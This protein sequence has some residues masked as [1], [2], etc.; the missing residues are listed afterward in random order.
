MAAVFDDEVF[1]HIGAIAG[2]DADAA[3]VDFAGLARAELVEFEN[4]SAFDQHDFADRS[5]HGASHFGMQLQLAIF[6]MDWDEVARLDQIDDQLELFLTGVSADMDW[7]GGSVFIDDVGFAAEEMVDHPVDGFFVAGDD[8]AGENDRVTLFDFGMLMI[9]DR[10][11][12]QRRHGL[13]LRAADQDTDFFRRE[14]L[15]LP[16]IDDQSLGEFDVAEIFG[17][18]RRV[19]HG[20]SD[21]GDLASVLMGEFDGEVDAV[22]RTGEARNEEAALGVREDLVELAA[23]GA[24]AGR[25]SLALDVGGILKKRQHALFAIFGEGVQIE[26]L[27]VGGRRIDFEITG[28]DDDAER[29]VNGER[30]TIDQAVRD[31][32]RMDGEGSG[33]EAL[34]SAHLA[35][36]GIVEQSVLVEL[37]LDIGEREFGAPDG[38]LQF[39]E[40]PR[41][42]AN[43]VLMA[44]SEDDAAHALAIF[45]K[46]RNVGDDD[47]DAEEFGFGEH[48]AGVD[49]NDV[50]SPADGHAVHAELAEASKRDDLQF[51]GG[52]GVKRMLA[53]RQG[54]EVRGQGS[55]VGD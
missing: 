8:A 16:G 13:A 7:R 49:D 25:V 30:D 26:K 2:V 48:E 33:L 52:H 45:D 32:D 6:T 47:I 34:V 3:Y 41:K 44:V 21:K 40:K 50:I 9:V 51:S 5:A 14:I 38:H 10:R 39:G 28:M 35:Q 31:L 20:A 15:H 12:R 11:P 23:D 4:V 54:I 37:V 53:Q 27:V 43:V 19:V 24:L 1:N 29:R 36:V 18:F 42:S 46:I 55:G 22:N 17:D